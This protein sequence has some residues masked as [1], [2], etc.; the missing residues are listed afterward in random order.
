MLYRKPY[1][2]TCVNVGCVPSKFL[3]HRARVAHVVRT[4]SRFHIQGHEPQVDLAAIVADKDELVEGHRAEGLTNARAAERLTRISMPGLR[5]RL[6]IWGLTTSGGMIGLIV[7][8]L[9]GVLT[10][11]LGLIAGA[12]G[13][14]AE[15]HR[16]VG[17]P[18]GEHPPL[19]QHLPRSP[20]PAPCHA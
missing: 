1:G 13:G 7:S 3:L 17:Q 4:G 19:S 10:G 16:E 12:S 14:W 6:V 11:V 8:M 18:S 9:G 2:S 20:S 5:S 15:R